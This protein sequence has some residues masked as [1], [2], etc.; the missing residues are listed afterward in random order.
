MQQFAKGY[1]YFLKFSAPLGSERHRAQ[2]YIG[3]AESVEQRF[4]EHC[5]G[6]GAAITRAAIERGYKLM[7]LGWVEGDRR[8]ERKFKNRKNT[9]KVLKSL[10]LP[11]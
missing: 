3:F 2:Y 10:G 1:V 8:L 5:A 4:A 9:K 7:L 11:A 6:R